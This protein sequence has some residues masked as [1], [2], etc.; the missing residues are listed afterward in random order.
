MVVFSLCKPNSLFR[1]KDSHRR[2]ISLSI[3]QKRPTTRLQT[4]ARAAHSPACLTSDDGESNTDLLVWGKTK[5][6]L[7][8]LGIPNI[9]HNPW[10][11]KPPG[12]KSKC[13]NRP[14]SVAVGTTSSPTFQTRLLFYLMHHHALTHHPAASSDTQTPTLPAIF[15]FFHHM[16]TFHPFHLSGSHNQTL[17]SFP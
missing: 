1:A 6:A 15:M 8:S 3:L 17:L 11:N 10:K 14:E 16:C 12:P 2:T 7:N 4:P 9:K 13:T 5:P